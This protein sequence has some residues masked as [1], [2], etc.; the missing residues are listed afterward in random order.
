MSLLEY[1]ENV[2]EKSNLDRPQEVEYRLA[3]SGELYRAGVL[4][5][6]RHKADI[7]RVLLEK[8][9]E[10][11]VASRPADSY[12]QELNLRFVVG[13]RTKSKGKTN[14]SGYFDEAIVHDLSVLLTLVL[15]RLIVPVV[16]A[17]T[18]NMQPE[19]YEMGYPRALRDWAEP[20][21]AA[22]QYPKWK[23]RPATVVY[24]IDGIQ[25]KSHHPMPLAVK[26]VAMQDL[27]L[28]LPKTRLAATL[29]R[30]A[31]L[32]ATA[33]ELIEERPSISY[34][35]LISSAETCAY[36]ALSKWKP[37]RGDQLATQDHL[38]KAARKLKISGSKSEQLALLAA[39]SNPWSQ[40]K[41][42]KFLYDRVRADQVVDEDPL[43]P[44]LMP[45]DF[46]PRPEK[47]EDALSQIYRMRSG[48]THSG[49]K[50]P[51]SAEL[52]T[53]PGWPAEIMLDLNF[54]EKGLPFPPVTWFE[55]I[56]SL[57]LRSYIAELTGL[58]EPIALD[59]SEDRRNLF[60]DPAR[61]ANAGDGGKQ[62]T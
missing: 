9:L 12:P 7:C 8:P 3:C 39:R 49:K 17:R 23:V 37:S 30:A 31:K 26:S 6:N 40:R 53:S 34:Q 43:Y 42:V 32:Y 46:L 19:K 22:P 54:N 21:L 1:L 25:V 45:S 20:I 27:L 13:L 61:P 15:R 36:P 14:F 4:T 50:Y 57:A 38:I 44:N 55:R 2:N 18:A 62:A 10:I 59:E 16:K 41:F 24:G 51:L 48:A 47:L 28:R 29:L 52:G 11:T 56:V 35:L 58:T 60:G 33:L 5:A